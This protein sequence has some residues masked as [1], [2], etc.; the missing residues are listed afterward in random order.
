MDTGHC[1]KDNEERCCSAVPRGYCPSPVMY[2][3]V[4]LCRFDDESMPEPKTGPFIPCE[5]RH[6]NMEILG[7]QGRAFRTGFLKQGL[8]QASYALFG[9]TPDY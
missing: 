8:W 4:T 1:C 2:I 5:R 6:A 3:L 9:D 7:I